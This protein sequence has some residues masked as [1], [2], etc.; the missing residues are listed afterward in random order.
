[1]AKSWSIWE[2]STLTLEYD[3]TVVDHFAEVHRALGMARIEAHYFVHHTFL[4]PDQL[5]RDAHRLK[6]IPGVIVHG[7]YD[8]ICPLDG[9]WALHKV[10]PDS[11]LHIIPTAGHAAMEPGIAAALVEAT[12]AMAARCA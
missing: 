10:W 12:R 11:E 8:V 2:G 4:E 1:M 3:P 5:L 7:R 6:D 9:A